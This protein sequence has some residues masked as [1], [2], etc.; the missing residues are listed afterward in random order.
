MS[1]WVEESDDRNDKTRRHCSTPCCVPISRFPHPL[2]HPSFSFFLFSSLLYLSRL[3]LLV[4]STHK[5]I[6]L[7][8]FLLHGRP[9]VVA[10]LHL[11]SDHH[12]TT[13][14]KRSK[15]CTQ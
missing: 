7:P 4:L 15:A 14:A 5:R 13:C 11:T 3:S 12:A 1:L 6:L 10:G 8:V 9:L 2:L